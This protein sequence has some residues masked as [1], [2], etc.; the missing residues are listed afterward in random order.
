[1]KTMKRIR[2]VAIAVMLAA[3]CLLALPSTGMAVI[4][5]SSFDAG[6]EGWTGDGSE[7]NFSFTSTGGN[8]GGYVQLQPAYNGALLSAFAPATYLGD[9]T[10]FNGGTIGFDGI[11]FNPS[12]TDFQ[13]YY[14]TIGIENN[15]GAWFESDIAPGVPVAGWTTY[16]GSFTASAFGVS[17]ATWNSML[18]D[19]VAVRVSL[20]P[21]TTAI[22]SRSF[23]FDNFFIES[24]P[25][26]VP[27]PTTTLLWLVG[28]VVLIRYGSRGRSAI[29][30]QPTVNT[31]KTGMLRNGR[32]RE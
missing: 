13:P 12:G 28:G 9:L 10:A 30:L 1:M 11:I 24:Q 32:H 25:S 17:E 31:A 23:G 16:Q 3:G 21:Y 14:G 27:E 5:Q 2:S 6:L 8:P 15:A 18:A 26:A 20:N 4:I 7:L 19:V 29:S 22:G